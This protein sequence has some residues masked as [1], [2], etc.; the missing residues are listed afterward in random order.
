MNVFA[1]AFVVG[2]IWAIAR[3]S[4]WLSGVLGVSP[5]L[6]AVAV[7]PVTVGLLILLLRR[8]T[9]VP[10]PTCEAGVCGPDDYRFIS[11]DQRGSL[12]ECRCGHQYVLH[13]G[14]FQALD[15]AG[16]LMA[17]KRVTL[18][19]GWVEDTGGR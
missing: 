16:N 13:H 1:L 10:F 17:Y 11:R 7:S 3:L 12:H 9:P 5:W 6:A 14:T 18:L 15:K 8:L 4:L 19:R 2:V